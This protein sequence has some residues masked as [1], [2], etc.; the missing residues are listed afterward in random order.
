MLIH[1]SAVIHDTAEIADNV[2]IGPNSVIGQHCKVGQGTIIAPNVVLQE[3][4]TLGENCK[5]SPMAVL[6]GEPQDLKFKGEVSYVTIGNNT[7]IRE[8]VTVNRASGEGLTTSLGNDCLLMA[9]AHMGHNVQVG[10]GVILINAVQIGGHVTVDD[11]SVISSTTVVHQFSRFGRMS[12]IGGMSAV[13]Q[14]VP[15]FGLAFG[16]PAELYTYNKVG[17]RRQGMDLASRNAIKQ[18]YS[19]FLTS[20]LNA[21]QALKAIEDEVEMLPAVQEFVDFVRN[22]K[23]GVCKTAISVRKGVDVSDQLAEIM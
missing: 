17:L 1:P 3:Y 21:T 5:I 15:P 16:S 6:G 10:N 18:V 8:G 13:R 19:I 14:D 23:R 12:M 9:Y 7:Q 11:F 20:G 22:S 4:V 2:T